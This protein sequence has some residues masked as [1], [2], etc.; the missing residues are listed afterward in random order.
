MSI[1]KANQIFKALT[2]EVR[3][4]RLLVLRILEVFEEKGR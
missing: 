2:K 1:L 3:R 4:N